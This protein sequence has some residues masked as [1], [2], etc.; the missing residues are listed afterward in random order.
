L[1]VSKRLM[2]GDPVVF[3]DSGTWRAAF[4][5]NVLKIN[6]AEKEKVVHPPLALVVVKT[7]FHSA[8][9]AVGRAAYGAKPGQ[10]LYREE[11]PTLPENQKKA[12]EKENKT[13]SGKEQKP[14]S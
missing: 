5:A 13:G 14:Q 2:K 10:W 6:D 9:E 7:G 12:E 3:N 8:T 4:I 11:D 1:I